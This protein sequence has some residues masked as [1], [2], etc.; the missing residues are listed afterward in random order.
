VANI[1]RDIV[2][3]Q[4]TAEELR[5][6]GKRLALVPTMGALHEGHLSLIRIARKHAD[7]VVTTIFVNPA[8]FGAGEDFERYPRNLE[9]DSSLASGAGAG[10]I[11]APT[12]AEM[13]PPGYHT[14][15]VVEQLTE[16]LEGRSRPGHFRGVATVVLKFL[17]TVK[18]HVVLFGQKD[19]QQV[20]VIRRMIRDLNVDVELIVAPIIRERDGLAMSS[21]NVYLSPEQRKEAP[22]LHRSLLMAERMLREGTCET[23]RVIDEMKK[24]IAS[25][26]SGIVDYVSVADNETLEEVAVC[27][28]PCTLLVS[29]AVRFGP[30]RLIDNTVVRV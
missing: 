11:F 7:S 20:V 4:R 26:S 28:P 24:L 25:G 3:M 12:S 9:N 17:N 30:T 1:I 19:A 29:L 8:Q 2:S 16:V 10:I 5:R 22:V 13:Y 14:F 15:V 18:P 23:N 6:N 27:M 21:R